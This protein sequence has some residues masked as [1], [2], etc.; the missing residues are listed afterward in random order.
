MLLNK[1]CSMNPYCPHMHS[2]SMAQHNVLHSQVCLL[3]C[4]LHTHD[5]VQTPNFGSCCS[6]SGFNPYSALHNCSFQLSLLF[7]FFPGSA[8]VN[9]NNTYDQYKIQRGSIATGNSSRIIASTSS[10]FHFLFFPF[11]PHKY[12][13]NSMCVC[14]NIYMIYAMQYITQGTQNFIHI[15]IKSVLT[16][17]DIINISIN[18]DFFSSK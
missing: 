5:L 9:S 7:F 15:V 18:Q 16:Q 13:C 10:E 2:L 11:S 3:P 8:F 14:T 6:S 4:L 12:R 17:Q 1:T